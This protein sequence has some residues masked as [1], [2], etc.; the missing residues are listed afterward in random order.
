MRSIF[1]SKNVSCIGADFLGAMGA[2]APR[3]KV[4]WVRRT[5]KNLDHKFQF[6]PKQYS[7]QFLQLQHNTA[8]L[9][10]ALEYKI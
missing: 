9:Q 3:E 2:N 5:Q 7:S 8:S 1:T 10:T 6:R 4:Q